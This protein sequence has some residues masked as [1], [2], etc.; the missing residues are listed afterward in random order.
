MV[1]ACDPTYVERH[2]WLPLIYY[3][4]RHK[5]Y[6]PEEHRTKFKNRVLM[7]SSHRDA[8]ILA[9]YAADL[10]ARLDSY[11]GEQ[12]LGDV[13]EAYRK[14][15]KA[16]YDFAADAYRF[17][18]DNAPC[19]ILCFD[20]ADFFGSLDHRILKARLKQLLGVTELPRDW[21]GVF[22][23]VTRYSKVSRDALLANSTF[24]ERLRCR[25]PAPVANIREVIEAG[26]PIE[27]G[28]IPLTH[29]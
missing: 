29:V 5:R 2:S 8:C 16:N 23:Y 4:K 6:K 15:G 11:Y 18:L 3:T 1:C 28:V 19:V 9:K 20:I 13:V 14:L 21:Y 12:G 25:T 17:A 26:I 22:R 27:N 7:Y 10:S 24:A